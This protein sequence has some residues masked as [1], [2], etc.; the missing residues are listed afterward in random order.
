VLELDKHI[1]WKNKGIIIFMTGSSSRTSCKHLF[2]RLEL[3][4]L[5]L[6]YILSL[7]MFMSQDLEHYTFNSTIHG[8]NIRNK[9]Q[10]HKLLT[11]LTI[12]QKGATVIA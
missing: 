12:Y 5:S 7:V 2:K 3:L 1:H 6:Q 11:A 10:L 8:F 4:I 9:L